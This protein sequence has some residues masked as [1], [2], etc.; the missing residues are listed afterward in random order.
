MSNKKVLGNSI[1][2][3]TAMIWGMA[4]AFQKEGMEHIGP[5]SFAMSRLILS[6]IA[7][8]IMIAV[9]KAAGRAP[10]YAGPE[11]A[12][13]A[14]SAA[15]RGGVLC[16]SFLAAA[17][18]LQQAA[19]VHTSAGKAGFITALYVVLV[20]VMGKLIFRKSIGVLQWIAVAVGTLGL[21]LLCVKGEFRLDPADALLILCAL[22]FSFQILF[23]D[24]Y[25]ADADPLEMSLTQFITALAI[26]AAFAFALETPRISD[27]LAAGRAIAYCGLISGGLGYS[28]QMIGQRYADPVAASLILA[29]ESVFS[30]IG[31]WILLGEMLSGRELLGCCVM[32]AAIV[33][34]QIPQRPKD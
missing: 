4:F 20:P 27:M 19:I 29:A 16:G 1:L 12:S 14:R 8:L 2:V 24:R 23:C 28:F 31:G 17:S 10:V 22:T 6:V 3:I 13:R 9:R 26:S 34:S 7:A 18:L 30:V 25:V 11:E 33:L 32:F 5:M 15:I 21:Y